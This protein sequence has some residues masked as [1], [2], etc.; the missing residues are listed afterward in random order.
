MRPDGSPA[1]P[2]EMGDVL[3]TSLRNTAMPLIRY[4]I[5]DMAFAPKS[6]LC[7]CGRGLPVFGT[8]VGRSGDFLRT[9]GG[10]LVSPGQVVD[11]V[12]PTM[13]SVIDLQVIQDTDAR[14]RVLVVQRDSPPAE[15]D[16]ERIAT[17]LGGLMQAPEPPRVERVETIPVTPGGKVRTLVAGTA[18]L[19]I[20]R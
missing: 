14:L 9:A 7:S 13:E 2:G 12:G 3:V 20:R 15:T 4:R 11:A 5:G 19:P 6:G 10:E 17:A 8:V 16:R 18:P 1:G